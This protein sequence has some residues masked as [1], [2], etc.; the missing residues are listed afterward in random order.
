MQM[1][2]FPY[3]VTVARL[4]RQVTQKGSKTRISDFVFDTGADFLIPEMGFLILEHRYLILE[5]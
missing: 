5:S 2:A 4:T 3:D 1:G